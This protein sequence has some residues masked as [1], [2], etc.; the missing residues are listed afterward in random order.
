MAAVSQ[1]ALMGTRRASGVTSLTL[2]SQTSASASTIAWP[3]SIQ[4]GDLAVLFDQGDAIGSP[5]TSVIATG[6]TALANATSVVVRSIAEYKILTGTET[7]SITGLNGT[8]NMK[9]LYIFRGDIPITSVSPSVWNAEGTTGDP[10]LQTVAA[11]GGVAPLVVLAAAHGTN[12]TTSFSTAS[13]AFDAAVS[14]GPS[15][16]GRSG[17]KIYNSS[18]LDHTVDMVDNNDNALISG[19]LAVS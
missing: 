14:F 12:G 2:F 11:S 1:M 19:F 8:Q 3:A 7:G 18:P 4:A 6:F 17:Y 9:A 10:A 16:I 13:P 15:N 5:P